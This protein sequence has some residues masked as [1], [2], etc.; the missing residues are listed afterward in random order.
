M[1]GFLQ[2]VPATGGLKVGHGSGCVVGQHG[3]V[4]HLAVVAHLGLAIVVH[5]PFRMV[6]DERACRRDMLAEHVDH[7]GGLEQ[8]RL[9]ERPAGNASDMRVELVERACLDGVM[10]GIVWSRSQLV[11]DHLVVPGDEQFD[12]QNAGQFEA[13][14]QPQRQS[15][16]LLGD[17]LVHSAGAMVMCRMLLRCSLRTIGKVT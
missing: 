4:A 5:V 3:D 10:A 7:D 12:G 6:G 1:S 2:V 11:D 14:G 16:R 9:F 13:L 17:A 8:L 15:V